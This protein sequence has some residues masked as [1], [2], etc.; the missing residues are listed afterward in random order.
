M[1]FPRFRDVSIERSVDASSTPPSSILCVAGLARGYG[2]EKPEIGPPRRSL[3]KIDKRRLLF[4]R[5]A[6]LPDAESQL[7]V[8][9]IEPGDSF[10][11]LP[12]ELRLT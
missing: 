9:G 12:S 6:Q 1:S 4:T 11:P 10:W 8:S 5:N 7:I 3:S 2:T